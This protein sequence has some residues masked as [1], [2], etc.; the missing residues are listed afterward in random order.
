MEK[1]ARFFKPNIFFFF[2]LLHL[3]HME[4]PRLGV[5]SELLLPAYARATAMPDPSCVCNL[6]QS[7]R[8]RWILNPL[9]EARDR[10]RNLMVPSQIHF[11]CTKMGTPTHLKSRKKCLLFTVYPSTANSLLF[12][13]G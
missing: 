5:Y 3:W 1:V 7:S 9:S 12:S 8:Q 4:V 6:H 13:S 10:T 11:C 2:C